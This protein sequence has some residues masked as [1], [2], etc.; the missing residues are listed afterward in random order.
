MMYRRVKS[1][2]AKNKIVSIKNMEGEW[3]EGQ[4]KVVEVI[5]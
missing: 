3:V 5:T 1:R 2:I 4:E